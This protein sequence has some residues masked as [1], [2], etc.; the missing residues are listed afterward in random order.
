MTTVENDSAAELA[1]KLED[2]IEGEVRFDSGS[3]AM[4]ATDASNYRQVPIGVVLPKTKHDIYETVRLCRE[5]NV[6]ILSRG[7]GTSL[8]GQC[9]NVAVV[10]DM[11]KYYNRIISIDAV[12]KTARIQPGVVLDHLREEANKV[13]LTFGPDPATHNHCTLGGMI[14]NNSCGTHSVMAG[15]TVDNVVSLEVLTYDGARFEV[16]E[17]SDDEY[18]RILLAGGR[19]GEIYGAMRRIRDVYA[20]LIRERYPPIPRRVSGYN[21]DQLLPENGFHLARALTGT[22]S[23]CVTILEAVVRLVPNP[24]AR[25][26]LVLGYPS[27]FEAADHVPEILRSKPIALEGVDNM[28]AANMKK[29]KVHLLDLKLLPPGKGWLLVEFGAATRQESHAKAQALMLRLRG[30]ANAPSMKLYDNEHEEKQVWEIR[31][32]GLGATAFV[33][34]QPDTWEGWEDSAVPVDKLGGY[35]RDLHALYKKYDLF[36][37]LYGHFGQGCLHTRINFDL[38]TPKGIQAFRSFLEEASDLVVR[39]GGS[40]S[41]EHGDGQSKAVF[42]PKMYGPELVSA[43]R[44]FK[45][46]WDPQGRMNPGKIVDPYDPT[47]NLRLGTSYNPIHL[48]THFQFPNDHGDFARA[49]LRCVGVGKCRRQESGTMCPS[50]MVTLEE[51]HSTR[52]RAHLLF[53]MMQGEVLKGGWKEPAVK[54]ALDLCLSCKGCKGDC[55]VSVDMATY[56]A[57]FLAHYFEGRLRPR[58]A[59]AMGRIMVWARLASMVPRV[60]NFFAQTPGLRAVMKWLGGISQE[61]RLP[62][63]AT[64]TFKSWFYERVDAKKTGPVV[65]LWPDTFNN[66]MRPQVAQAAVVVLEDAGFQVRLP[67][68][69]LCCGRPLYDYG[70]LDA[71]KAQL[72]QILDAMRPAIREGLPLIGLEPSCTAVFRD[73]M[74]ELLPYDQDAVRLRQQT[75][76]LSEWLVKSGYR[77]KQLARKA[78][79]QKHCHHTAVMKFNAEE[80]MLK[81]L[82]LDYSIPDSGCCG[83][84]GSFGFEAD[85]YAVSRKI[86]E[87]VILPEVRRAAEETLILADGFSCREQIDDLTGREPLHL[88]EVLALAIREGTAP[89]ERRKQPR[90][91]VVSS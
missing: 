69:L 60:V 8:A 7:G 12:N 84:A 46:A 30:A 19:R 36:G 64:Q 72:T 25:S 33:P 77:P 40:F 22:E 29:Q 55:P 16:G 15:K 56:K 53:E 79:V 43:F 73:E 10:M 70:W 91:A 45:S 75:F 4:Y 78:L 42:L 1:R 82:G 44:Q 37:A 2:R 66:F 57:E 87:R 35:L 9:C 34:G 11:S 27:I 90:V 58:S 52:G 6:P 65:L 21:L 24:E 47:D 32:G 63:F 54:D 89:L 18:E 68:G 23:T 14:G 41:G 26:L 48:E 38:V 50:Y 76:L 74:T 31:E 49:A 62:A 81:R 71:A 3:R 83:M 80:E 28:L 59:Y 13:G 67:E 51:K 39:Y 86:G 20:P 85:H 5:Y 61:R 17:T 88:A